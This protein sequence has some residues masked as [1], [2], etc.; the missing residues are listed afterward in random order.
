V[1]MGHS[2]SPFPETMCGAFPLLASKCCADS[3]RPAWARGGLGQT[4]L[5]KYQG[6]ILVS[7]EAAFPLS[8]TFSSILDRTHAQSCWLLCKVS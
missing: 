4:D 6:V 3:H 2:S 7:F 8:S 1:Q 5:A